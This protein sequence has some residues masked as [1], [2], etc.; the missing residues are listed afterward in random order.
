M[1]NERPN[2]LSQDDLLSLA[3]ELDE[4]LSDLDWDSVVGEDAHGYAVHKLPNVE[5][6]K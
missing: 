3:D 4:Y 1:A 2:N 6:P 5:D